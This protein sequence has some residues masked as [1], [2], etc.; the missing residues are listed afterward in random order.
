MVK[1]I[2]ESITWIKE[3]GIQMLEGKVQPDYNNA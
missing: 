2:E 3:S 1:V